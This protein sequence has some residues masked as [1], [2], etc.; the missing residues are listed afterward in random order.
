LSNNELNKHIFKDFKDLIRL[1]FSS[2]TQK[3]EDTSKILE[4]L[5]M[6]QDATSSTPPEEQALSGYE[7][8]KT[9][10]KTPLA[11]KTSSANHEI[12]MAHF[13][14]C[15]AG[16]TNSQKI[17]IEGTNLQI[18]QTGD[19]E[20]QWSNSVNNRNTPKEKAILQEIKSFAADV[21][22]EMKYLGTEDNPSGQGLF[23]TDESNYWH[24][25]AKVAMNELLQLRLK[26]VDMD[27]DIEAFSPNYVFGGSKMSALRLANDIATKPGDKLLVNLNLYGKHWVGVMVDKTAN[28]INIHYMDSEQQPMPA[29]LKEMLVEV[30]IAANPEQQ[31]NITETELELQKYNNCGPEVIENFMQYLTGHRLSQEE[32]VPVHALL[33]E[34]AITLAGDC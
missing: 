8:V 9:V 14:K 24:I 15:I 19:R 2:L 27:K 22:M 34:D 3:K 12:A 25:Y 1:E 11:T 30:L 29:L 5:K 17:S 21:G 13:L 28:K 31:I 20:I 26:S 6:I 7:E 32:A 16:A 10:K 18:Q 23:S 33:F 4:K